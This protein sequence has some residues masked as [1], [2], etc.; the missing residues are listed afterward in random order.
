MSNS[1]VL[2]V[3]HKRSQ[4]ISTKGWRFLLILS[5]LMA[6]TSL[7]VDIYLPAMPKMH[8]ELQGNIELT[9][10]GFLIGFAIGQLIWGPISDRIGRRIPLMVGM[11][12][13]VI[14]AIGCA[15]SETMTQI[16]FWRVFQALGACTGPMIA[17]AMIRDL[18][19]QTRAAQ[20]LSTLVIIMA[21]APIAGPLIGGQMIVYTSWHAIFW[22]LAI[23]GS[24]MLFSVYFLPETLPFD[25]RSTGSLKHI[26][27]NYAQLLQNQTFMRY[28]LCVTFYY[29][30]AY[31]FITGSP[32]I[33]ISYYGIAEQYYGW[34]F[35]LNILGVM[36]LSFVNRKWVGKYGIRFLLSISTK[37]AMLTGLLLAALVYFDIG[38]I[39][40]IIILVFV[41][42]SMNGIIAACATAGALDSVGKIAGSAS[43]LIGSLQYGSGILSSFLLAF[44]H[45]NTPWTMVWI[46]ALAVLFSALIILKQPHRSL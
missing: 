14:G 27:V 25:K 44:F 33:Y 10:T 29:V 5:M 42:F 31:A 40:S 30:G 23:I 46:M 43:A 6:F 20:M 45:D 2:N 17:R 34:L 24:I 37:V 13:F 7:S 1:P 21:I 28:A 19:T 9:I 8:L 18:Y 16:V 3:S 36:G 39:Y 11:I 26:F 4:H 15:L 41:I 22:L 38:G 32:F 35:G 12:L